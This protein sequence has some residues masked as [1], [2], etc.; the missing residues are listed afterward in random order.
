MKRCELYMLRTIDVDKFVIRKTDY[1]LV[2][3]I[4][5][6]SCKMK[7]NRILSSEN[8]F[9][10]ITVIDDKPVQIVG[11]VKERWEFKLLAGHF[12][13]VEIYKKRNL[14]TPK[15]ERAMFSNYKIT[16]IEFAEIN[17]V[18]LE[19]ALEKLASKLDGVELKTKG[20][21]TF[22]VK[23][24]IAIEL[25]GKDFQELIK[26]YVLGKTEAE[27]T[28]NTSMFELIKT[29]GIIRSAKVEKVQGDLSSIFS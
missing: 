11:D 12:N 1:Y 21:K 9:F 19:A 26:G 24:G 13:L 3:L 4:F 28:R 10:Y 25:N 7:I 22:L 23:D 5:G 29:L 20:D 16:E 18:A 2:F 14:K 27:L 8:I 6:L 17:D 15:E